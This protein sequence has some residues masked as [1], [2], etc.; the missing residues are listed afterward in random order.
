M[1]RTPSEVLRRAKA[2]KTK[3]GP[4]TRLGMV[5]DEILGPVREADDFL[6][7]AGFDLDRAIALAEAEE[8]PRHIHPQRELPPAGISGQTMRDLRGADE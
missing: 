6:S 4:V 2:L 8:H 3:W 5:R 7:K 1:T